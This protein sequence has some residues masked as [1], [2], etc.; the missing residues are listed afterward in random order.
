[1]PAAFEERLQNQHGGH[2]VDDFATAL[3]AHF[4]FAQ[5]AVGL[6]RGEALVP[7]VHGEAESHA[8]LF[9]EL[10]DTFGAGAGG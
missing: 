9:G 8:Q 5:Q 3:D 7:K 10:L 6:G 4:R 2:A 1:M